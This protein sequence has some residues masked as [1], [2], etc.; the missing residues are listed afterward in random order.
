MGFIYFKQTCAALEGKN[1]VYL[2]FKRQYLQGFPVAK[3]EKA[4]HDKMVNL[5]EAML[6]L[7][8]RLAK[9]KTPQEKESLERQ[10]QDTDSSID[11]LV[12]E[13]Y[14]LNEDEIKIVEG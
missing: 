5:V 8:K 2:R 3:A 11:S 7:H 6:E 4:Q 10:I 13:L 12:Y 9:A 14:G 1:D